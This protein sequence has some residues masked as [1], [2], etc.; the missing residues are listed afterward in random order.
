MKIHFKYQAV[1]S[2]EL[3]P[4]TLSIVY[5]FK[6]CKAVWFYNIN[7][8][9]DNLI[10]IIHVKMKY[11]LILL[12]SNKNYELWSKECLLLFVQSVSNL[13]TL[14]SPAS[15]ILL[16][17]CGSSSFPYCRQQAYLCLSFLKP[18]IWLHF[19]KLADISAF[20][21]ICLLLS[22]LTFH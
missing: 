9:H 15:E 10:V 4:H 19:I 12:K 22:I 17:L 6:P 3:S 1:S 7:A 16:S 8:I 11:W 21:N 13:S 5:C 14:G 2:N 18:S 20:H